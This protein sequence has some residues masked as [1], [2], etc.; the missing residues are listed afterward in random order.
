MGN[1]LFMKLQLQLNG[2]VHRKLY[3]LLLLPNNKLPTNL[4]RQPKMNPKEPR[5]GKLLG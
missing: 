3:L 5:E 4:R 1:N 2:P